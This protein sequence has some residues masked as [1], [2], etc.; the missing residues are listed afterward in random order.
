[1]VE[2]EGLAG[3]ERLLEHY[4]NSLAVLGVD[5]GEEVG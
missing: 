2:L 5:Q 3:P 4:A 1:M